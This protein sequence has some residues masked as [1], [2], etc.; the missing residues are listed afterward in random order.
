MQT[1]CSC[2]TLSGLS[3]KDQELCSKLTSL[4]HTEFDY[5]TLDTKWERNS[6][7]GEHDTSYAYS[8]EPLPEIHQTW[9]PVIFEW[10]YKIVDHFLLDRGIVAIAMDYVDRFIL[11]HPARGS[12]KLKMYQMIAM[13][14]L[15]IAMKVHGGSCSGV[16][17][18]DWW[19][20]ERK[21]FS[22]KGFVKLSRGQFV[23]SDITTMETIIL[24]TLQWKMNPVTLSCFIDCYMM[25]IPPAGDFSKTN[26]QLSARD[27]KRNRL[28][29][30]VL[31]NLARYFVELG[32]CIR[33]ITP[34]FETAHSGASINQLAPSSVSYA[35]MLLALDMMT[36][37]AIPQHIRH[38]FLVRFSTAQDELICENPDFRYM[39]L[40]PECTEIRALK[41]LIHHQFDPNLLF[42]T[43]PA[44]EECPFQVAKAA[45]MFN[46]DFFQQEVK[47]LTLSPT[48]PIDVDVALS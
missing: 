4:L 21:S 1:S 24:K 47:G 41:D 5:I 23:P 45:G 39:P 22:L 44:P 30:D 27:L 35:A 6:P 11:M 17:E 34:Y 31:H 25:L 40:F 26:K 20:T 29:L 42:T 46:M 12:I 2:P 18:S 48:T 28:A 14:S 37:S 38:V 15:Y 16:A 36:L 7:I 32:A 3:S 13:S 10:F 33:G 43:L 9:R 8:K 19:K